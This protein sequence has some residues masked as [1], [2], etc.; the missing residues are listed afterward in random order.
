MVP[1]RSCTTVSF[2]VA[3]HGALQPRQLRLEALHRLDDVG[4]GLAVHVDDDGRRVLVPA[5]DLG[6]LQ[7]VDDLGHVLQQHR[8]VV[9]VGDDDGL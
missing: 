5:A 7:A 3:R 6:V 8:R 9:A 2:D 4:A 1:V